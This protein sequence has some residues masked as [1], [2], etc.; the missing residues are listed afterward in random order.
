MSIAR[1]AFGSMPK[2]TREWGLCDDYE[3]LHT[4]GKGSSARVFQGVN[5]LSGKSVVIKLFKKIAPESVKKEIEINC[6]LLRGL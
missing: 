1:K 5:V 4:L 6:Q 3:V 2:M